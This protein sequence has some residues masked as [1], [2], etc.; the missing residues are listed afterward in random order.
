[1][2]VMADA[3]VDTIAVVMVDVMVDA[4][5][6]AM[7]GAMADAIVDAMVDAMVEGPRQFGNTFSK[8]CFLSLGSYVGGMRPKQNFRTPNLCMM[9][10]HSS[11]T[12]FQD[13]YLVS[14]MWWHASK[15]DFQNPYIVSFM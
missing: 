1:M 8:I 7:V 6:D 4:M 10:W 5:V 2:G 3:M 13:S 11:K 15:T 14:Y 9:W 12:D